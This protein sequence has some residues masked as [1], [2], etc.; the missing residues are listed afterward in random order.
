MRPAIYLSVRD[1]LCLQEF[2]EE[3]TAVPLAFA[4][5]GVAVEDVEVEVEGWVTDVWGLLFTGL[6]PA[7]HEHEPPEEG[8]AAFISAHLWLVS[9]CHSSKLTRSNAAALRP[10][11][12]TA[13]FWFYV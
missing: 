7:P 13:Q 10:A 3:S 11:M 2:I 6:V 12:V 5:A 4:E 1:A 8:G 9:R